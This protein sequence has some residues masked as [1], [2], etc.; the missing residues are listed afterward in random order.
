[1]MKSKRLLSL[2]MAAVMSMSALSYCASIK[3]PVGIVANAE[4]TYSSTGTQIPLYHIQAKVTY[5]QEEIDKMWKKGNLQ[6]EFP[7]IDPVGHVGWELYTWDGKKVTE[8]KKIF[9]NDVGAYVY[10]DSSGGKHE[11]TADIADPN[12]FGVRF[13]YLNLKSQS[14]KNTTF[15]KYYGW[16]Q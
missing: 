3:T 12:Y 8:S 7:E 16:V 14:S 13:S 9:N 1:M 6:R 2:A 5:S 15:R 4:V 10:K 11:L